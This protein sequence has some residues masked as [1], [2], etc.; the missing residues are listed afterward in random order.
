M[1]VKIRYLYL[2][3]TIFYLACYELK[4]LVFPLGVDERIIKLV[5]IEKKVKGVYP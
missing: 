5:G 3:R 1:K 2:V 4:Q